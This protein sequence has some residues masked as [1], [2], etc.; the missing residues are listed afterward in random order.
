L[1]GKCLR[2]RHADQLAS[3]RG[4]QLIDGQPVTHGAMIAPRALD[5]HIG[6][7]GLTVS[8]DLPT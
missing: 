5:A 2:R 6:N 1:R 7:N 4:E 3:R 8:N